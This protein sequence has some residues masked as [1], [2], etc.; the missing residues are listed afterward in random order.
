M[1]PPPPDPGVDPDDYDEGMP[2]VEDDNQEASAD[3]RPAPASA[4]VCSRL[5]DAR[6]RMELAYQLI[7][8]IFEANIKPAHYRDIEA[9]DRLLRM[10]RGMTRDMYSLMRHV[11]GVM[12][13]FTRLMR[14]VARYDR[15]TTRD[16]YSARHNVSSSSRSHDHGDEAGPP[17]TSTDIDGVLPQVDP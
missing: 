4:P 10:W 9:N 3:Q 17:A 16:G 12:T 13:N 6:Y 2:D 11:V 15:A 8:L 5:G 1:L 14:T 7:E